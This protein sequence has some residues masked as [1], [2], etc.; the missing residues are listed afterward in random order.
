METGELKEPTLVED[1]IQTIEQK[2]TKTNKTYLLVNFAAGLRAS[3]WAQELWNTLKRAQTDNLLMQ[4]WYIKNNSGF[5]TI[6]NLEIMGPDGGGGAGPGT[7][8]DHFIKGDGGT[9]SAVQ[10]QPQRPAGPVGGNGATSAPTSALTVADRVNLCL[11]TGMVA[12]GGTMVT[13][14]TDYF[15]WLRKLEQ[16]ALGQRQ[17]DSGNQAPKGPAFDGPEYPI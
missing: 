7:G 2:Y 3:L 9:Q 15:A 12:W 6:T 13:N 14:E 17:D 11:A 1:R 10:P 5:N 4:I 16:Y 8:G